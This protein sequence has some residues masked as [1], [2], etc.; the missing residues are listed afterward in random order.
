MCGRFTLRASAK[1]IAKAFSVSEPPPLTPRYNIAPSQMILAL[2][3][4]ADGASKEWAF[5]KWGLVPSWAADSKIGYRMINA[6]AESA[7]IKPSFRAAYK[8]RRC[9]IPTDGYYEWKPAGK[10]KQPYLFHRPHDEVFAFAGLWEHWQGAE[11]PPLES[12]TLLTT[13]PN[14]RAREVHD[15]MPVILTG[16][17]INLWLDHLQKDLKPLAELLKPA[18][19]KLLTTMP[20]STLVNSPKNE[21][22]RCIEPVTIA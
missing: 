10:R 6:R 15:R 5:L 22:P 3:A 1:T 16:D 14:A 18:P 7:A 19:D 4:T 17:A 11:G 9:V 21:D 13:D 12:C 20:V 8:S 2:R